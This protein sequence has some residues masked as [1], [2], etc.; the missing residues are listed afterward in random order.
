[1]M[2][3]LW[4]TLALVLILVGLGAYIY[5]VDSK[6]P[7]PGTTQNEKV[8]TV[9]SGQVNEL[10]LTSG[11]QSSTLV[12][13]DAGWQ[14]TEPEAADADSTEASSLATNVAS[15]EQTRVVDEN[16]ADLAPYGLAEP[17]IKI[18]F[19]AE[20]DKSGEVHL[21]DKTPTQGDVYAVKPGTKRV[22]LV[23]S[24]LETTFDKKPFDLRDKRV[25]RFERDKVDALVVTRGKD[26]IR[27]KREGSDWK[28]EQPIAGRGDYSAIEGLLTRLSTAGMSEIVDSNA[29][30]VKKYGLDQPGMTI[31]IGSGSSQAVLE[32][33][34]V[35]GEKPYARDRSRPLVFTLDTTLAED[36]KKPFDQYHKKDLFESRPFS[37]DK[38]RVTRSTDGPAKT[39]EFSKIKRDNADVWQVAPEGGQAADADRP[40]V[41]DLLNKLTDLKMGA[42]V[43]A[44]RPTGLPSPVLNVSVSYDNGKFERV[45]IGRAGGQHYGNREG[46]QATG[47]VAAA[48]LEA[49]LQALDGAIAPPAKPA[50]TSTPP[51]A[52][53]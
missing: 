47:E 42:F 23:S 12:K 1:M 8:F 51:A 52:K 50:E 53:Q 41:D 15:M 18:A 3:G 5:F 49:A 46:E 11:G 40:K 37:M 33:G 16:A 27:L 39:W 14:L 32:I 10:R 28:V 6:S 13:K 17:R 4:S 20:G 26:T 48:T 22:F 44:T 30:D 21:G 2:R 24:Y 38:V 43:D 9:E 25:V 7:A 19:K 45:R 31:S 35:G 29:A 34:A 36:L